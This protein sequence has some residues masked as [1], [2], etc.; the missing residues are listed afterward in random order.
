MNFKTTSD[1]L[2]ALNQFIKNANIVISCE[3]KDWKNRNYKSDFIMIDGK[4]NVGFEVFDNEI[5]VFYFT[6]HCH[7]EDYSSNGED[8]YIKL[9]KDFLLELFQHQIQ[10]I[11][12]FKGKSQ[13]LEKYYII[14]RDGREANYIGGAWFG[15]SRFINPFG[16]KTRKSTT[17][18]YDKLK[19][20]F[21]TRRSKNP[22]PDAIEVIDVND[23]CYIEILKS[24][25]VYTY[26][27]MEID[28]D[29]YFG[30]YYWAPAISVTPSGFYDT[31]ENAIQA[32][33]E[34]L[35]CRKCE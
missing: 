9:A 33:M 22:A 21:T 8:N 12:F 23:D 30:M 14:Y 35:K 16:K 11:E 27:I 24:H 13:Y 29:D 18:Q 31:K 4:N 7:F 34:S 17:W 5:I 2:E 3:N 25:K 10:H 15:L 20:Y 28:F 19:G 26:S 6:D 32:A 1:L